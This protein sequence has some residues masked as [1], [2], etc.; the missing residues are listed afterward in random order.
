MKVQGPSTSIS[1]HLSS[2]PSSWLSSSAWS[3]RPSKRELPPLP[4][5]SPPSQPRWAC[6]NASSSCTTCHDHSMSAVSIA[7]FLPS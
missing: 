5:H 6:R 3:L 1:Q 7:P 2:A 4:A